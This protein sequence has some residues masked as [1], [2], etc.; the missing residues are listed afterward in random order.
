MSEIR[1]IVANNTTCKRQRVN[2][3]NAAGDVVAKENSTHHKTRN[4]IPKN[5]RYDLE[6]ALVGVNTVVVVHNS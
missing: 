1:P 3:T 5:L 2:F 6:N 4:N